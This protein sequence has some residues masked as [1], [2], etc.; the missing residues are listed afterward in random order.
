VTTKHRLALVVQGLAI[1]GD[2]CRSQ[3]S[4]LEIRAQTCLVFL[5]TIRPFI[6]SFFAGRESSNIANCR[7]C[8]CFLKQH[9]KMPLAR[10]A[11]VVTVRFDVT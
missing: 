8:H 4:D 1:N 3:R 2:A 10:A 11:K 9:A 7:H 5:Y 6:F